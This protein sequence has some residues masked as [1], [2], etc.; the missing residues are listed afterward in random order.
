[1]AKP[2]VDRALTRIEGNTMNNR[3]RLIQFVLRNP[4]RDGVV[5]LRR[6]TSSTL[7]LGSKLLQK[8]SA[9]LARYPRQ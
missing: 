9:L 7:R 6:P 5:T 4:E 3:N 8:R 1:M 2:T